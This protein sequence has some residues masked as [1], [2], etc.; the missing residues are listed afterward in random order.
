MTLEAAL[1]EFAALVFVAHL[2]VIVTW[3]I[4]TPLNWIAHQYCAYGP[5]WDFGPLP[6]ECGPADGTV[7]P[8]DQ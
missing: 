1:T 2:T 8:P 5:L 4:R 3:P 7:Q 6:P